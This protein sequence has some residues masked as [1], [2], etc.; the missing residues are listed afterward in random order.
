MLKLGRC[1]VS[2]DIRTLMMVDSLKMTFADRQAI[3][4]QCK[5]TTED[6]IIITHGTS[7]M[8]ETAKVLGEA[9]PEGKTII[10]TGAMIPYKFGSSDGLFIPKDINTLTNP[11]ETVSSDNS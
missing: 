3:L 7:T 10:I 9:A 8:S 11:A 2:V 5:N 6:H 4:D 1:L